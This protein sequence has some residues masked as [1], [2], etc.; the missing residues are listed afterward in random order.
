MILQEYR[1]TVSLVRRY[2]HPQ[3]LICSVQDVHAFCRVWCPD[4]DEVIEVVQV[5]SDPQVVCIQLR[6]SATALNILGAEQRPNGSIGSTNILPC[7]SMAC[8]GR[9][10]G[11]TGMRR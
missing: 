6:V 9:S 4:D 3:I 5:V 1:R 11:C 10:W 7:H 8:M 2:G